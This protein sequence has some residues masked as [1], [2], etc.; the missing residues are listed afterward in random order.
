MLVTGGGGS[1]GSELCR[2]ILRCQPAELVLLGHGEN[3]IFAIYNELL[4]AEGRTGKA[5]PVIADV[6]FAARLQRVFA[7]YR[8]E[9]VFH[10]AAHKHVPLMET[11]PGEAVTNNVWGRA[12][13]CRRPRR[14]EVQHFV[15]ISTDKAVNPTSVMGATKR[16]AELLVHQAARRSG[17]C[18][19]GGAFWQRAGQPR[20]RGATSLSSRSPRAGR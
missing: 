15:L 12:T 20:Q 17:H 19:C 14:P 13:W 18:L 2:Q 11:N 10:A 16:A 4:R 5:S 9:M 7:S 8:P 6:R 1:I 3:S